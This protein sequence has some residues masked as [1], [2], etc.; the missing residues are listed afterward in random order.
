MLRRL[1]AIR[2]AVSLALAQICAPSLAM[3]NPGSLTLG[4]FQVGVAGTQFGAPVTNLQGLDAASLQVRLSGGAG[5]SNITVYVQTSIDQ[6][7]SWFDV[8]AFTY[9][10]TPGVQAANV[11]GLDKASPAA[12]SSQ[13]L[14]TGTIFD[15]PLGD[16][17]Q[18]V[19]VSTGTYTGSTLVSVRAVAR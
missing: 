11:S 12:P 14:A 8:A 10:N 9:T 7:Q 2:I 1:I 5:G 17:L 19:V 4:D 3:D 13:G 6:G 18:A 15:G 16:R